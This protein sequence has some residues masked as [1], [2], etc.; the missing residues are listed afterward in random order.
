MD[1]SLKTQQPFLSEIKERRGIERGKQNCTINTREQRERDNML[2][3]GLL[4]S[5][6]Q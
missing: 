3:E 6:T 2:A 4:V 5:R 1:T